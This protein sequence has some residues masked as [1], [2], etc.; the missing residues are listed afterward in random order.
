[1]NVSILITGGS[2]IISSNT[3]TGVQYATFS[4][5]SRYMSKGITINYGL[6]AC[7]TAIISD[8]VLS[9]FLT[10]H[11]YPSVEEGQSFKEIYSAAALLG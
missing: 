2:P 3:I 8:N 1:M 4:G 9:G 5:G 10:T 6:F 11:V 7:G